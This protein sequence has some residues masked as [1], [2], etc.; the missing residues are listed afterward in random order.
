MLDIAMSAVFKDT[1]SRE[2]ELEELWR[3]LHLAWVHANE[4]L[5]QA[6][7]RLL[8]PGRDEAMHEADRQ[9]IRMLLM[10]EQKSL[11]LL[12][13]FEQRMRDLRSRTAAFRSGYR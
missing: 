1:W 6:R 2:R 13:Q 3:R 11:A 12:E 5:A 8:A 4:D 7:E 10:Q 9:L